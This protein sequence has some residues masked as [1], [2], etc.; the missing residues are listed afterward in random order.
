MRHPEVHHALIISA[1]SFSQIVIQE[2]EMIEVGAGCSLSDLH[3]VLLENRYEVSFEGDPLVSPKRSVGGVLIS[4]R[5]GGLQLRQETI[6]QSL[7]GIEMITQEGSQLKWGGSQ[8]SILAG[9]ALHKLM[10]G[11]RSVPGL[12]IKVMLKGY[13]LPPVR[14]HLAWTFR[15]SKDLW[16]HFD[17]LRH[18]TAT[19]ERLDCILSGNPGEQSFILAQIS[20]LPEEMDA[21]RQLCPGY[22]AARQQDDSYRLKIFFNQQNLKAYP[23]SC[24]KPLES[25]EY[26]WI[27]GL[28]QR[29]WLITSRKM[30]EE[31]D[32]LSPIW[33]Q[34]LCTSLRTQL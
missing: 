14:I 23:V 25:G 24:D 19:W 12:L 18:L 29:A 13:L 16:D 7:F 28:D 20:G 3:R 15:D 33:K 6:L 22:R 10:H 4:G 27:Q 32:C 21:F 34:Q 5:T 31:A 26:L 30:E 2:D 9:P 8:R 1:R 17:A 11:I